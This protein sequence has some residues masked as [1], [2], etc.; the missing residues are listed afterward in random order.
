MQ[1]ILKRRKKNEEDI[2]VDG[3]GVNGWNIQPLG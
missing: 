3:Y 1:K 2:D